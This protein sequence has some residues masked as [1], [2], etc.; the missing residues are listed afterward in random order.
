MTSIQVLE[1]KAKAIE[2]MRQQL[3]TAAE[4]QSQ[5]VFQRKENEIV[6]GEFEFLEKT[7]VIY[8]Q[9]GTSLIK[10][11]LDDARQNINQRIEWIDQ[12]IENS[13]TTVEDLEK[14]LT[15]AEVEFEKLRMP[16]Q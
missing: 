7:D 1:E 11:E 12:Q 6:L 8:K 3:Q 14:K 4:Q 5:L 15:A 10:T 16:A 13:K 2:E 9:V